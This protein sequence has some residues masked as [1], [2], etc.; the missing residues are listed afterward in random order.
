MSLQ[1]QHLRV[2][3]PFVATEV[4]DGEAVLIHFDTGSY[5]S[6]DKTGAEILA[7]LETLTPPEVIGTLSARHPAERAEVEAAV[8][9]FVQRL[10][11][12]ALF[13]ADSSGKGTGQAAA[14]NMET[15]ATHA[16]FEAPVL[17]KYSDL[18]DLLRLDPIHDVDKQGWPAVKPGMRIERDS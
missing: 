8:S 18:E 17:H 2:N 12:E 4:I 7:L 3:T 13:V 6:T 11:E 16:R 15:V 5:Y 14:P 1:S 10:E 9:Q